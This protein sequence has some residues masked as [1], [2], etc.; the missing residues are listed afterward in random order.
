MA[1]VEFLDAAPASSDQFLIGLDDCHIG[2]GAIRQQCEI[3]LTRR[4]GKE[5]NLQ[6]RDGVLQVGAIVQNDRHCDQGPQWWRHAAVQIESGQR[7]WLYETR[8]C[9]V[10]ER[11]HDFARRQHHQHQQRCA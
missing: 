4:T 1:S 5:S 11:N 2:I 6:L 3:E 10:D 8:Q 9:A 7:F